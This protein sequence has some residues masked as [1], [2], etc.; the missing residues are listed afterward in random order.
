[1]VFMLLVN[2]RTFKPRTLK[3][4]I[5]DY[6]FRVCRHR[7]FTIKPVTFN[8]R[9]YMTVEHNVYLQLVQKGVVFHSSHSIG[10]LET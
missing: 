9:I 8:C 4:Y 5:K 2:S 10:P 7:I 1:M 6:D 3:K